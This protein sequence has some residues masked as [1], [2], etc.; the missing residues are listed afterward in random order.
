MEARKPTE[1][2]FVIFCCKAGIL[3]CQMISKFTS[4][5]RVN[6]CQVYS[7]VFGRIDALEELAETSN[8]YVLHLQQNGSLLLCFVPLFAL[9]DVCVCLCPVLA[10]SVY[11]YH[12]H[13][14]PFGGAG[15]PWSIVSGTTPP[16]WFF[17]F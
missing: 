10:N 2:A 9:H 11:M 13:P 14:P 15:S 4:R 8:V 7:D 5:L 3:A 17:G 16:L 12:V 1:H 6:G